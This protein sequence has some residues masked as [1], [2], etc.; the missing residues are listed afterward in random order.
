MKVLHATVTCRPSERE[1]EGG[2]LCDTEYWEHHYVPVYLHRHEAHLVSLRTAFQLL[3]NTTSDEPGLVASMRLVSMLALVHDMRVR[4]LIMTRHERLH[5]RMWVRP[6]QR[7]RMQRF[8][9]QGGRQ[10]T[11]HYIQQMEHLLHQPGEHALELRAWTLHA[12]HELQLFWLT[13]MPPP[14]RVMVDVGVLEDGEEE[15]T[16]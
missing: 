11:D 5:D 15:E 7:W 1:L 8:F 9:A 14:T 12:L 4:L 6:P 16:V 2:G 13:G 10:C 3:S